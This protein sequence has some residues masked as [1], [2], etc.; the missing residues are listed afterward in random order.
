MQQQFQH[1]K[2][3]QSHLI[4]YPFYLAAGTYQLEV[5]GPDKKKAVIAVVI[6]KK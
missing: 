4:N 2:A 3:Q 5:T 1:S 6:A